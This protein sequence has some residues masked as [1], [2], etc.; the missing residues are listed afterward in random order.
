MGEKW[1]TTPKKLAQ[2]AEYQ[3][4]TG[5]LTWLW[6]LPKLAQDLNNNNNNNNKDIDVMIVAYWT[7]HKYNIK[8]QVWW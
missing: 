2:D 8:F 4:H 5:R 6:F 1:Q 7:Q 3:S